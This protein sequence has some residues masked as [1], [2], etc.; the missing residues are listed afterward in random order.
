M[1]LLAVLTMF[2][3]CFALVALAMLV[4][5]MA[6]QGK[7]QSGAALQLA[8]EMEDGPGIL[9]LDEV[10]SIAPWGSI[11]NRFDFAEAMRTKLAESDLNWSVGRLTAMMLFIGAFSLLIFS[12]LV[13]M[14]PWIALLLACGCAS[15]P[16]MYV[17]RRRAKRFRRFEEQFPD[18]LDFL[19][20][21]LRAGHPV[22][23]CLEMLAHEETPPLS[24]EMRK[25]A[26]ERRLG[27][28]LDQALDNLAKRMPLLNVRV[29]VAAVKLQSRTG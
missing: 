27:L 9:K 7:Q 6:L 18:A 25:T 15:L 12:G 3:A 22:P 1:L 23:M 19:A 13:S 10:S 29:F 11:L 28:P 14:P 8:S 26:E 24:S 16:Y 4:A 21:S 17:L 5:T 20:R 2:V